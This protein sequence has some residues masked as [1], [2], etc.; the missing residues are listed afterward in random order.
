MGQ[1]VHIEAGGEAGAQH[2]WSCLYC[3][4]RGPWGYQTIAVLG[5]AEHGEQH[6]D[7]DR[8]AQHQDEDLDEILQNLDLPIKGNAKPESSN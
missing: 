3:G 5:G 1:H 2:R 6:P 4:T 7:V 8:E